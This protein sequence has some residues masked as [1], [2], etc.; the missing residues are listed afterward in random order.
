MWTASL[1]NFILFIASSPRRLISNSRVVAY[2]STLCWTFQDAHLGI[3]GSRSSVCY[4]FVSRKIRRNGS[5]RSWLGLGNGTGT[6]FNNHK[7]AIAL[8]GVCC[9]FASRATAGVFAVSHFHFDSALMKAREFGRVCL[10][11]KGPTLC[12]F[13]TWLWDIEF[14][15]KGKHLLTPEKRILSGIRYIR[16]A[17]FVQLFLRDVESLLTS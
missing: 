5:R 11:N 16:V 3:D 10:Y 1:R 13:I 9:R 15:D 7:A 2:A 17:L 12:S 8:V 6:L 14:D 4:Y